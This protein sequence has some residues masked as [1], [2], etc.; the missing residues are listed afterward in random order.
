MHLGSHNSGSV[1]VILRRAF[2]FFIRNPSVIISPCNNSRENSIRFSLTSKKHRF[3]FFKCI[4]RNV[5]HSKIRK[6][7]TNCPFCLQNANILSFQVILKRSHCFSV[8]YL[9]DMKKEHLTLPN[10]THSW[11]E[12]RLDVTSLDHGSSRVCEGSERANKVFTVDHN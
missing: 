8:S 12:L 11:Y 9:Y 2:S 7:Q 1:E 10:I 6:M 5:D 3:H 4:N